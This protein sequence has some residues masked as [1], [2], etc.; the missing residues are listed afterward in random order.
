MTVSTT[1]NFYEF[2]N[3]MLEGVPE[4]LLLD[5]NY[6]VV[7]FYGSYKTDPT[8]AVPSSTLTSLG[9]YAVLDTT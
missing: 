2:G 8:D 5:A 1:V 6:P 9:V 7:A 4:E 3:P